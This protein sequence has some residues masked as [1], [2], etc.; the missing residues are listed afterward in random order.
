MSATRW[1]DQVAVV[2]ELAC[3]C[4]DRTNDEQRALLRVAADVDRKRALETTT[5]PPEWRV[6]PFLEQLA[7][8]SRTLDAE[9]GQRRITTPS[10]TKAKKKKARR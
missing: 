3:V 5:N 10:E 6:R 7:D 4:E 2:V 1:L 8:T 9:A